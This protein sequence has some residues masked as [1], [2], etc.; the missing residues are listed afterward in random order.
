MQPSS[1]DDL[2]AQENKTSAHENAHLSKTTQDAG[3]IYAIAT[4]LK[5]EMSDLDAAKARNEMRRKMIADACG[6][7]L[8]NGQVSAHS[9]KELLV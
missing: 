6:P 3:Y 5:Q 1:E 9:L 4:R 7:P 8:R 2:F